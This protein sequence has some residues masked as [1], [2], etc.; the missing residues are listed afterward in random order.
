MHRKMEDF[1]MPV[2][3]THSLTKTFGK[4]R[5]V[6]G[7]DLTVNEGDFFGFIG[8]NGAGKST[9]IRLLFN[10]IFP[11][12]GSASIFG[13]DCVRESEK[14]KLQVGYVPSE[15]NYYKEMSVKELL[16]YAAS[17]HKNI[18]IVRLNRLTEVF[19]VEMSKKIGALS[20]GNRKKV[21]IVQALMHRPK[22]LVLDE[23]TNGLDPLMQNRLFETLSQENKDGTAIF[24]SSHN[25]NE[26]QRYC[27]TV[28][29]IK[30]GKLIAQKATDELTGL[31]HS[32]VT[33]TAAD[34]PAALAAELKGLETSNFEVHGA[35]VSFIYTG[36]TDALVAVLAHHKLTSL[37]ITEPTLEETF[38]HYYGEDKNK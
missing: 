12:S 21:A 3:E 16:R 14:I 24:F 37:H 35:A 5:G 23:P 1:F 25:L 6:T 22:L 19:E 31:N 30:E 29:I 8:P 38:M 11:T 4:N 2:I 17:F 18:D 7:I 28:G 26:V 10:F 32:C 20:L 27:S 9:T 34:D 15:I 33:L 36:G 13:L